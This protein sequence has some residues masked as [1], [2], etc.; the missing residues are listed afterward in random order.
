[1]PRL[2]RL[3]FASVGHPKARFHDLLLDFRNGRNATDS[4]VWLR[5]GGGKSSLLNLFFSLVRPG[6]HGFFGGSAKKKEKRSLDDYVLADDRSVI[7]AE[8]ELESDAR[9]ELPPE[10]LLT[11]MMLEWRPGAADDDGR[12][13]KLY[14]MA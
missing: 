6:H 8:W 3:R 9:D 13:R 4:T 12:L 14:F 1:M 2:A 11:G 5:N 7:A 10:R